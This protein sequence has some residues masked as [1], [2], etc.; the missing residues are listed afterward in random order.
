MEISEV[1]DIALAGVDSSR[2][3]VEL[4]EPAEVATEAVSALSQVVAELAENAM[5]FSGPNQRVRLNGLFESNG[6]LI[7]ISDDGVGISEA[8]LA[9]LN[10]ILDRP[11]PPSPDNEVTLGITMVARLAARHGILV[12]LVPGVP[13]TTA[14]VTVP[15]RIVS[16]AVST[17]QHPRSRRHVESPMDDV[18]AETPQE[19][20]D[21]SRYEL[22]LRR[23]RQ[24]VVAMTSQDREVA[25]EFLEGVFGP[26]R[27]GVSTH[28]RPASR[29][30]AHGSG[31]SRDET[32]P[33]VDPEPKSTTTTELRVRVPGENFSLQEDESS[34]A[35]SEAAVDLRSA[36]SRFDRGRRD[37]WESG[38][39]R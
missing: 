15:S 12:R 3:D 24:H 25:E 1:I 10:R 33:P 23:A 7:T 27:S 17:E 11:E 32:R 29:R 18:F 35:S 6:Y 13:G 38:D 8:L 22:D 28:A 20:I 4:V 36:L 9:A 30:N 16:P 39:S 14:R 37:A 5:A 19:S 26:L 31:E 21:L 2:V 34:I